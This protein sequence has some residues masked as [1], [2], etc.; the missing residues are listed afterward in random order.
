MTREI[1]DGYIQIS[2]HAGPSRLEISCPVCLTTVSG[3]QDV[4]DAHVDACLANESRMLEE[5]RLRREQEQAAAQEQEEW[6]AVDE[7]IV[8]NVRGSSVFSVQFPAAVN[9]L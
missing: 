1:E 5:G 3:D 6:E 8:G 9:F 7:T 4:V 2:R